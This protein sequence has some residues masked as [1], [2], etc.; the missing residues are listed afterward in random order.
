MAIE[1]TDL[2]MKMAEASVETE[3]KAKKAIEGAAEVRKA[4]TKLVSQAQTILDEGSDEGGYEV[5]FIVDLALKVEEADR[6]YESLANTAAG[7][8][9]R[10]T[11]LKELV[12]Q[13]KG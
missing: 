11:L 12:N 10:L 3:G 9:N 1:L 6:R 8:Q 7:S 2:V 13:A 4:L 5:A